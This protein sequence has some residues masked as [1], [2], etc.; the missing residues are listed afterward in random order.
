MAAIVPL[1]A[2]ENPRHFPPLLRLSEGVKRP[3][4]R[5][6]MGRAIGNALRRHFTTLDQERPNQ[7]G[8]R[9]THFYGQA[10]RG[11]QQ[12][13]LVGGDGVKVEI[14]KLGIA[15]RY[16]GGTIERE[17]GGLLTIPVNPAAYGHRAREFD[18]T[19]IYF[20]DGSGILVDDTNPESRGGIGEVFYRLV[21]SV[22]QDPDPSVLPSDE[23]LSQVALE[24]GEDYIGILIDRGEVSP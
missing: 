23:A 10:R 19:P 5:K 24:A 6:V 22:H 17:D 16:F 21:R 13:E 4:V 20:G 14:D 3:D 9:R 15:Q 8:G 18:L 2:F 7:L 12:P 1:V 11:V